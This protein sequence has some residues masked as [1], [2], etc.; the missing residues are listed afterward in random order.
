MIENA[1][2]HEAV[3]VLKYKTKNDSSNLM[4]RKEN[5]KKYIK[6]YFFLLDFGFQPDI[7]M[8]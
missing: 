5:I 3:L 6:N 7:R 1:K 8:S 4:R 2:L